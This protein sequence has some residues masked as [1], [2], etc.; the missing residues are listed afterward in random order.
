MNICPHA[1]FPLLLVLAP[2]VSPWLP[3]L[4]PPPGSLPP[5]SCVAPG[6]GWQLM[7]GTSWPQQEQEQQQQQRVVVAWRQASRRLWHVL[8]AVAAAAAA[9][10]RCTG[11]GIGPGSC[12]RLA[13]NSVSCGR[14]SSNGSNC[15]WSRYACFC[16]RVGACVLARLL[17]GARG[18]N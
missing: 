11:A 8:A 15:Q 14:R 13:V 10:L 5:A 9:S 12:S 3:A 16:R 17:L 7:H 4:V 6:T 2:C 18:G 1:G